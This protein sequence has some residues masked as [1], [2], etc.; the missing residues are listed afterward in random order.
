L[1]LETRTVREPGNGQVRIRVQAA[2]INRNDLHI[3][4]GRYGLAPELPA[5]LGQDSVAVIDALGDGVNGGAL[6]KRVTTI[7]AMGPARTMSW[8]TPSACAPYPTG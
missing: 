7:G 2:P 4:R 1:C 5:V 8:P 6:D 3:L